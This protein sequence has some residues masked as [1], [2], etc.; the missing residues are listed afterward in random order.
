VADCE[1]LAELICDVLDR[2]GDADTERRVAG[3]ALALC[4]KHPVY[5]GR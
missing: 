5:S 1:E 3:A 4:R 2:V